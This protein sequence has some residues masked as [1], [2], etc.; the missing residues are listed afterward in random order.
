[1]MRFER[2]KLQDAYFLTL[3]K[4]E[5]D[6]GFFARAWCVDEFR[7][8]GI[9]T[10]FVQANIGYNKKKGTLRGFHYQSTPFE[11]AKLV[12]CVSGSI[13][14]VIIDLRKLSSTYKKWQ[15][16]Y[17]KSDDHTSLYIPQGF[18]HAYM[19]LEDDTEVF[20]M[21]SEFYVPDAEKGIRWNDPTF[22]V[23]WP[24]G[25]PKFISQKDRGWKDYD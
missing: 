7:T 21:V 3:E 12:R 19:T 5:D 16:F 25:G 24:E 18:A 22:S 11:E 14:D 4:K 13:Y 8:M 15:G 1:M 17:L 20:Y 2:T 10:T 6:R 9:V 23:N